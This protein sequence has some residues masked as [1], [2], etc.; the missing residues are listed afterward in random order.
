LKSD[1][2]VTRSRPHRLREMSGGRELIV[3]SALFRPFFFFALV[4]FAASAAA[5]R[6]L[7]LGLVTG[8]GCPEGATQQLAADQCA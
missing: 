6:I 3:V 8:L 2:F 1:R 5:C 4:S 7:F